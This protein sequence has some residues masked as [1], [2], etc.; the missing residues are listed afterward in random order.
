ME[1]SGIQALLDKYLRGE[2]TEQEKAQVEA[3]YES[4]EERESL[5]E[6]MSSG[7]KDRMEHR[8]LAGI[9]Q[10]IAQPVQRPF[11]RR[12]TWLAVAASIVVLA[13]AAL[14]VFKGNNDTSPV[15]WV[16]I[17]GVPGA[18]KQTVLPD[19]S[20]VWLNGAG[21]VKYKKTTGTEREV[22]LEGEG[23]FEVVHN[24]QQPFRVHA[25]DLLIRDLGTAFN[26]DAT[27]E[28]KHIIITVTHGMVDV[29]RKDK[30]IGVLK[31]DDQLVFST[32]NDTYLQQKTDTRPVIA[33]K[34][35]QLEFREASFREIANRLEQVYH[36]TIRF[37][38]PRLGD[39]PLTGTFDARMEIK[40]VLEILCR[41]NMHTLEYDSTGN[42]WN[43]SG[44]PCGVK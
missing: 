19:G 43:I 22:W 35:G 17:A 41:I 44:K 37:K 8:V 25:A 39:C 26:I 1:Q 5:F 4:F 6:G 33:W 20:S 38:D 14:W 31:P 2:A 24:E 7:Q 36:T 27:P 23:F 16:T 12:Y 34:T 9:R 30:L 21:T 15:Q 18:V 11:Y 10:S 29:H 13:G 32:V 42:T 40:D 28:Q 3:Y